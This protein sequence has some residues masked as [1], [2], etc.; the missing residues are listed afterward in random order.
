MIPRPV[1][2]FTPPSRPEEMATRHHNK[3]VKDAL[4]E[5]LA[6]HHRLH[7]RLHFQ[8]GGRHRYGYAPRSQKYLKRK[9]REK[10]H[11]IDMLYSGATRAE[12][13]RPPRIQMSGAAEGGKK[14]IGG[15]YKLRF[16]FNKQL[17]ANFEQRVKMAQRKGRSGASARVAAMQAARKNVVPQLRKE[18]E[19]WAG[20][21]VTWA[22][23]D[24]QARY[25][26]MLNAFQGRRK[27]RRLPGS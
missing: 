18:M 21:E 25:L 4:R 15:G 22:A 2:Q 8:K 14:G 16:P 10:G 17:Q 26:R 19:R 23:R 1:A 5:T 3:I 7:T 6:E 12:M 24:F 27:R 9:Q 11:T 20:D 13:T